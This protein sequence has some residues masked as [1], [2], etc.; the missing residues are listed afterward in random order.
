MDAP[1]RER[2]PV[3][4]YPRDVDQIAGDLIHIDLKRRGRFFTLG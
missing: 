1:E 4:V 3:K 2:P